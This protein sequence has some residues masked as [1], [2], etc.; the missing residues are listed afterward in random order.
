MDRPCPDDSCTYVSHMVLEM[1][2]LTLFMRIYENS[3][4]IWHLYGSLVWAD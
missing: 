2:Y 4:K 1:I 3:K